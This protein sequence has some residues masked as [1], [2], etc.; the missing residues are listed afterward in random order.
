MKI[1]HQITKR[2]D[3]THMR[4]YFFRIEPGK[5]GLLSS[6]SQ[7]TVTVFLQVGGTTYDF[8]HHWK[9]GVPP[10]IFYIDVPSNA[11]CTRIEYVLLNAKGKLIPPQKAIEVSD[12]FE[13]LYEKTM[14]FERRSDDLLLD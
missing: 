4:R 11:A 9:P 10:H 12:Q 3:A 14:S 6:K 13:D 8:Q 1:Q 5:P 2:I 7:R